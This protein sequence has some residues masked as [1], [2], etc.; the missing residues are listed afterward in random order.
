MKKSLL[1]AALFVATTASAGLMDKS[2]Q[3]ASGLFDA[4]KELAGASVTF[5][6]KSAELTGL[7]WSAG[8]AVEFS[9]EAKDIAFDL[10]K[11]SI[12][13][14]VDAADITWQYASKPAYEAAVSVINEAIALGK[15][16]VLS[17]YGVS[18]DMVLEAGKGSVESGA[19]SNASVTN[20]SDANKNLG[21]TAIKFVVNVGLTSGETSVNV[22]MIPLEKV[23]GL[24]STRL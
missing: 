22:I 14:S 1:V 10:G 13:F 2:E 4:S 17:M 19:H 15:P 23:K 9:I 12:T 24:F 16:V 18:K 20:T 3:S 8:K 21:S 7:T 6:V 5:A 11:A